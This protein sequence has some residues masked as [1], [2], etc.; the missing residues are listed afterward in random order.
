MVLDIPDVV[1]DEAGGRNE[2]VIHPVEAPADWLGVN[3]VMGHSSTGLIDHLVAHRRRG[4]KAFNTS[5]INT[6]SAVI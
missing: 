6:H 5:L 2:E 1:D 3:S 4:R